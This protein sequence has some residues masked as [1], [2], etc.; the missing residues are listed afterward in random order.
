[1]ASVNFLK[2]LVDPNPQSVRVNPLDGIIE[3]SLRLVCQIA[4]ADIVKLDVSGEETWVY[5]IDGKLS[6]EAPLSVEP[7]FRFN[8]D[9]AEGDE[10]IGSLTV[11]RSAKDKRE[12]PSRESLRVCIDLL[13]KAIQNQKR[14]DD[15][16]STANR[17]HSFIGE[18]SEGVWRFELRYPM[19]THLRPS[20]QVAFIF[21]HA[22]LAE[23]NMAMARMYGYDCPEEIQGTPLRNLLIPDEPRN[24]IYLESFIR[25]GYRMNN[26][27]SIELDRQGQTRYFVNNLVGIVQNGY[28]IGAWGTQADVTAYKKLETRLTEAAREAAE[29]N[30]AKSAFL[31]NVSHE[32]R[33]PL[34]VIVGFAD[35]ALDT[36]ALTD[37]A[38]DYLTTIRRNG[39]QL[40]KILGEVLDLSKI[41]ASHLEIEE[42]R[43]PLVPF[44][45][46]VVN[47]LGLQARE[48]GLKL[49]LDRSGPLPRMV[50]TDPTR[51]RQILTNLIGNAVKF[52]EKGE[53]RLNVR[54]KNAPSVGVPIQLEFSVSDTGIGIPSELQEK[55]F[56]PFIQADASTARRFGG[57]GLGL[58]LSKQLAQALG[59][60]LSLHCSHI[61][62]GST[63]TFTIMGGVFEGEWS[64]EGHK[65]PMALSFSSNSNGNGTVDNMALYGKRI[66]LIE[67]SEDNQM[68][69]RH[70]LTSVGIEVEVANNGFEGIEKITQG[71]FDLVVLDIQMPGMDGHQVARSLR[72]KGYSEPIVALTAHALKE[73]REKA[74]RSGFN[75]YL[76]KPINRMALLK[77]LC[78]RLGSPVH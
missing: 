3:H 42:I 49:T 69:I 39:E 24:Y 61:G 44:L 55:I 13:V 37:E 68:L 8:F 54:L 48:K 7:F 57:T 15:L 25:N 32:I 60:D 53:V 16:E 47:F 75:E 17:Y 11:F 76:T 63:F 56:R 34:G 26:A 4:H 27:E 74:F 35:L 59:G 64:V 36:P 52:T 18:I 1:M 2:Q 62:T 51:L 30:R 43:F 9:L 38:R 21:E 22:Y 41:E 73:D 33:T 78:H 45:T 20:D 72:D 77:T 40:S 14:I 23:C 71:H 6:Y 65:A 5:G 46:E 12:G 67:D 70:Y 66:L 29:A 10:E 28:A 50:K 31:A 58:A 19:P